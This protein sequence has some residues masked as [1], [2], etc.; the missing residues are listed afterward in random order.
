[1][2]RHKGKSVFADDVV[3]KFKEAFPAGFTQDPAEFL[4]WLK[5]PGPTLS[6]QLMAKEATGPLEVRR[7]KLVDASKKLQVPCPACSQSPTYVSLLRPGGAD[8]KL[9]ACLNR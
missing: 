9:S 3:A 7:V 2:C 6:G 4:Q 8:A 1:M 5:E